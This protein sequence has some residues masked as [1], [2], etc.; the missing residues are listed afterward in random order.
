M[1][2]TINITALGDLAPAIEQL[3]A[4]VSSQG[5]ATLA[6]HAVAEEWR[7]HL[8]EKDRNE[9]NKLGGARTHFY[10]RAADSIFFRAKPSEIRVTAVQRGL[11]Q[12]FQGGKIVPRNARM[13]TIPVHPRAHGRRAGEF[14]DLELI[15][16]GQGRGATLMLARITGK[17]VMEVYYVLKP[18]VFQKADPTVMPQSERIATA[19][20]SAISSYATAGGTIA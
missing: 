4:R 18:S 13:L 3:K 19:G 5:A 9:P 12:R 7:Q 20:L 17:S 11:R 6:G 15:K 16:S 14:A 2:L 1:S 10:G 8:Y